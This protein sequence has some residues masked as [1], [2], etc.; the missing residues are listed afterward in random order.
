MLILRMTKSEDLSCQTAFCSNKSLNGYTAD[1]T[2]EGK[3]MAKVTDMGAAV[4]IVPSAP[5]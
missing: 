4:T 3:T 2:V 5:V 1:I